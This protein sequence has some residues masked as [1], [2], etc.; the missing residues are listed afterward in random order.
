MSDPMID[1]RGLYKIFGSNEREV[2]PL[3]QGGM[4]K[5]ELLDSHGCVLGLCD[6]NIAVPA[7][8]I[9][10]VMGLSGSGKSTLIRHINRVFCSSLALG[11]PNRMPIYDAVLDK[12]RA[13]RQVS[14][15]LARVFTRSI[16]EKTFVKSH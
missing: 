3:V 14:V 5:D 1:I 10:V 12:G 7:R 16:D 2:L 9:Q 8:S 13:R 11:Q 15:D 6:I 4:G